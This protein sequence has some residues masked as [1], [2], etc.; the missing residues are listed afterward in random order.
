M[1]SDLN[2]LPPLPPGQELPPGINATDSISRT[3]NT[4]PPTQLLDIIREMKAM[5]TNE[6]E[7][8]AELLN[9]APQLAYAVFQAMLLM[10]LVT[11]ET[12]N[13]IV[14]NSPQPPQSQPGAAGCPASSS[15]TPAN[16]ALRGGASLAENPEALMQAVMDL[17]QETIDLLPEDE[18]KQIMQLRVSHMMQQHR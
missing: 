10:N 1:T 8:A 9:Q 12:I 13:S 17:P 3:L 16:T 18:R 7:R 11:P 6:P 15:S 4:L 2:T 5:A 14:E